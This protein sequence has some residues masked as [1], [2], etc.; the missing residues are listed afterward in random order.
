LG[1][2]PGDRVVTGETIQVDELW[3]EAHGQSS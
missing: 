3:H 2:A 1:L